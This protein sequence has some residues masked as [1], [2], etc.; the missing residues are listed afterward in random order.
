MLAAIALNWLV[1]CLVD[2]GSKGGDAMRGR[3]GTYAAD[4]A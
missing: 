1:S 2:G 3:W 4:V